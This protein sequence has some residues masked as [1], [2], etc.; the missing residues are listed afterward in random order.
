MKS[1]IPI[2]LVFPILVWVTL[3]GCGD[4]GSD[5]TAP[6]VNQKDQEDEPHEHSDAD[7]LVWSKENIEEGEYRISLGHHGAH[8]HV[9]DRIEPAAIVTKAGQDVSDALVHCS[10]V[11]S[12]KETVLVEEAATVFEPKTTAEPA[13]YAQA[14]FQIPKDAK[15]FI[16]R[17]KISLPG[18]D[19]SKSFDIEGTA[20]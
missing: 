9:G 7:K 2:C 14:E 10:L 5:T 17:F 4:N 20:H 8:F 13:H 3:T 16:I 18:V 19:E 11:A 15:K 1:L 6:V 12:D